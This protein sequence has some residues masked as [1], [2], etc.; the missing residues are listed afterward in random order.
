MPNLEF[1]LNAPI[2]N[3]V[4]PFVIVVG[5]AFVIILCSFLKSILDGTSSTLETM[6]FG[7]FTFILFTVLAVC[8]GIGFNIGTHECPE[9]SVKT[10]EQ[11][12]YNCGYK[13]PDETNK[14]TLQFCMNC[15]NELL[16]GANF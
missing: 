1:F 12:C 4:M 7:A 15:G 2:P 10:Y 16:V 13:F 8:W 6:L 11:F 5:A 14:T 9:C 3:E